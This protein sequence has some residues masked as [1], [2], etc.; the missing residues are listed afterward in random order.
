MHSLTALISFYTLLLI[1]EVYLMVKF[2]RQGP[3]SLHT[4]RY[5]YETTK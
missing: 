1:I 2:V 5:H 3:S 4:G